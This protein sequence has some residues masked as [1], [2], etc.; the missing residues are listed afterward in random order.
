MNHFS[1]E[2]RFQRNQSTELCTRK[3][4]EEGRQTLNAASSNTAMYKYFERFG[5]KGSP[6][7]PA[8]CHFVFTHSSI[9]PIFHLSSSMAMEESRKN[10]VFNGN[11]RVSNK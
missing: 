6:S 8:S 2:K 3:K 9:R 1:A 5:G 11:G 7:F 4:E 10:L